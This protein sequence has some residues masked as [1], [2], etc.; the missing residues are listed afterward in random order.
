MDKEIRE[1]LKQEISRR[2]IKEIPRDTLGRMVVPKSGTTI[3]YSP[4]S[5]MPRMKGEK[6]VSGIEQ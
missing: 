5:W 2:K 4:G 6:N 1:Y 3:N